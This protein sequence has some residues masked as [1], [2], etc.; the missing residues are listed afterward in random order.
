MAWHWDSS[1]SGLPTTTKTVE[2]AT[3]ALVKNTN[4]SVAHGIVGC[5]KF[6]FTARNATNQML[7]NAIYIDPAAPTAN[8]IINVSVSI[9]AG[10]NVIVTGFN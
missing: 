6:N 4:K 1:S 7:V 9:P 10:L 8:F 3:G 2:V 5:T